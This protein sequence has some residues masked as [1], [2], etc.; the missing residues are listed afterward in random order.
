MDITQNIIYAFDLFGTIIFAITGAI[1]GVRRKLDFLGVVVFAC[2]V[3]CGGG[4]LRDMLIGCTPVTAFTNGTYIF[5]SALTGMVVFFCASKVIH[6][7]NL[8]IYC[9]A[10]GLGVFTAI[11]MAKGASYGIGPV[12]QVVCGIFSAVGGGV[13]RDIMS[14]SVPVVLTSDFYATA[15]LLGGIVY[16]L[17]EATSIPPFVN[18]LVCTVVV[19]MLRMLA[20]KFH[21]H[22]PVAKV[23][24]PPGE[25]KWSRL[26]E[27]KKHGN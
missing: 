20:V 7:W 21:I 19:V 22:L 15:S 16:L 27:R 11:G 2:T 5:A 14:K 13:I 6:R 12:G 8:I 3:G 24:L 1:K 17:L 10:L 26:R 9:D 23:H 25:E 4:M 18:F